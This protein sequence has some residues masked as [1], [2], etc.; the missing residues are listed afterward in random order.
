MTTLIKIFFIFMIF[1]FF[2]G[3]EFDNKVHSINV[4]PDPN[5]F[6]ACSKEPEPLKKVIPKYPKEALNA[7]IEA[8]VWIKILIDKDGKPIRAFVEKAHGTKIKLNKF[9]DTTYEFVEIFKQPALDAAMQWRFSPALM[10]AD[11][12]KMY[13]APLSGALCVS[14]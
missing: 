8:T 7:G 9:D 5:A 12:I 2:A 1:I 3:C 13:W 11:T 10:D 6:V 14:A 4:E